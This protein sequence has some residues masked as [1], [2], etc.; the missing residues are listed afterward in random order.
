MKAIWKDTV[1]ADSDETIKVEGS[2][3]F[4]QS[5][6]RKQ[7][8]NASKT[9]TESPDMGEASYFSIEVSGDINKDSV[10]YYA[11]PGEAAIAKVGQD[12]SGYVTFN[13]DIKIT[14]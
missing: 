6:L 4:P 8:I 12:F 2:V 13:K 3:Y 5:S 11:A 9:R 14:K 1:I 10:W 7:Y